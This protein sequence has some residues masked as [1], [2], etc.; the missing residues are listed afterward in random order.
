VL[1]KGEVEEVPANL[2]LDT[3][4]ED[5][6]LDSLFKSNS[7]LDF[8]N[9]F[10]A[11]ITGIGNSY[12]EIIVIT[13]SVNMSI[14][15]RNYMVAP[16][17]VL[18]LKPVGGDIIDGLLGTVCFTGEVLELNYVQKYINVYPS[19]DSL[20]L[21]GYTKLAF[22]KYGNFCLLPARIRINDSLVIEGE[23]IFD[24]GS[25]TS[26]ISGAVAYSNDM[27]KTVSPKVRYYTDYGG[28]G[29]ES[30]SWDFISDSVRIG[31][32]AL[33]HVN[34]AFSLDESGILSDGDYL[35]IIGNNILDRF[36]LFFDFHNNNLY[37]KPNSRFDE[38][39]LFDRLGFTWIDRC[40]T[41]GAWIITGLT[42]NS[43]AE[44]V[45]LRIDDRIVK[46]NS[47]PVENIP[48]EEQNDFFK[49]AEKVRMDVVRGGE[50]LSIGFDLAPILSYK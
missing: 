3:G 9:F 46:V 42:E 8:E 30:S 34:L 15:K 7:R 2:L 23:F 45:G 12:Q 33:P 1:V 28:I 25:P 13:D 31:S 20:D 48:L 38:P 26:T 22:R 39:Y 47:I 35:G 49:Q 4:A 14:G 32:Y 44:S 43:P 24:T 50:T 6:L 29:G 11:K 10:S 18:N 17:P 19:V 36:H 41:S 27:G 37:L 16:V 40:M 5:L 21:D